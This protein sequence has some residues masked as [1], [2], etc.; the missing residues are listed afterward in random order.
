MRQIS[1]L[2]ADTYI[3]VNKTI[4]NDLDRK[5]LTMLYQ[6]II[7]STSIGLYFSLWSDLD[8]MEIM[9]KEF[10]HHHVITNMQLKIEEIIEAREKLEALGLLKT[11]YKKG[12]VNSYIY[13]I[14]SP[15]SPKEFFNH[16][17][18]NVVLYNNIGKKE[19]ENTVDYF[20]LPN[21]NNKGYDDI[22]RSFDDIFISKPHVL[23]DVYNDNVKGKAKNNLVIDSNIDFNLLGSTL[24]NER[25]LTNSLKTLIISLAYIYNLDTLEIERILRRSITDK[26]IDKEVFRKACRNYYQFENNGKLPGLIYRNQPEYLRS[27]FG[28]SSKRA[29]MIYIFETATPYNFLRSKYNGAE[30]TSRDLRLVESLMVDQ[31][32]KPGVVNVLIDYILK[33]NNYKLSRSFVETI[34]GQWKRLNIETVEEAMNLAEKEHK[35]YKKNVPSKT[36]KVKEEKVPV[37]FDKELKKEEVSKEEIKEMEDI[38]KEFS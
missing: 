6:P 1:I 26:G 23:S 38:L 17:I 33:I 28:D 12:S 35:K 14:Y 31:G 37:W 7:G 13:E 15:F 10:T 9:S 24:S 27:P 22:T 19:Y 21:I 20:N 5:I 8:K 11:Y 3:V 32:L 2:P 16:P 36:K 18:L 25:I 4:M 30:P 29:K 34:A